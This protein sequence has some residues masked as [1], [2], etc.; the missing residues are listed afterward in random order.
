MWVIV[1]FCYAIFAVMDRDASDGSS[2]RDVDGCAWKVLV[3]RRQGKLF[4][5][6]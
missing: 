5:A 4:R 1:T 2:R 6:E 3:R